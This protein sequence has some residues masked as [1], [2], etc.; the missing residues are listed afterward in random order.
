MFSCLFKICCFLYCSKKHLNMA[1]KSINYLC[2]NDSSVPIMTQIFSTI[3]NT[4]KV[5]VIITGQLLLSLTIIVTLLLL[6]LY[7]HCYHYCPF[8]EPSSLSLEQPTIV[9]QFY[10]YLYIYT[11]SI[12]EIPEYKNVTSLY[13]NP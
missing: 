1:F 8:R 11:S 9:R 10:F 12:C 3:F 5:K 6:L 2:Q 7:H 13:Q 4:T